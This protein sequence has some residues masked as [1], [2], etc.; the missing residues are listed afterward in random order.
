MDSDDEEEQMFTEL[1]EEE[2]AAAAQDEEHMLILACLSGLY[3][4]K[5]IGR[6][7]G[8]APGHQKCKPRQRMEGY[9]ILY[10]DYFTDSSLHGETIFRRRFRMSR[11]LFLKIVYALREYDSYFRCKL[12]CTSMVGFSALQ[13]CTVAMRM[14]AYGAPSDSADDYLRMAESTTFDCFYRFCRTVIAVFEDI[15]LRSATIKD[16]AQ[17]L[18]FNEARGFSG[19]LGSI[20]CMHWKWKNYPFFWQGMYKGHKK[21]AL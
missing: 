14:L 8:S 20:D 1:F 16:T 13:K 7:G 12:D 10:T 4:E 5:A 17:I 19:M 15:Y 11:K 3:A 6:R 21:A 9:C 2:M 18:A